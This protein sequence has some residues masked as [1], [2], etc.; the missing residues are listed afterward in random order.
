MEYESNNDIYEYHFNALYNLVKSLIGASPIKKEITDDEFPSSRLLLDIGSTEFNLFKFQETEYRAWSE[1]FLL[2][3]IKNI[4]SRRSIF[5]E[6]HYHGDGLEA[7]SILLFPKG[8]RVEVFFLF[9]ISYGST[10]NTDYDKLAQTLKSKVNNVDEIHVFILR[11]SISY[12]D[13]A[14][15]VNS[16]NVLNM[17]GFVK[18]FPIKEFFLQYFDDDEFD[19]FL[20]YANEF[21]EKISNEITY[22][23]VIIPSKQ[24]LLDFRLKKCNMLENLNYREIYNLGKSGRLTNDDFSKVKKNY[25]EN[26]MY[27]AM[28][29]YND[30]SE[31]FISAEWLFDIYHN[32]MGSLDLTGIISGYLK[33]IEQLIYKIVQFNIDKGFKIKIHGSRSRVEYT[34]DNEELIDKTLGSLNEFITSSKT[35]LALNK[36][37]RG[38]MKYA[39]SKWTQYQRNGYFHKHNLYKQDNK[40][41]EIRSLTLF[42]YFLILGGI[43][44]TE[45]QRVL[46]GIYGNNL[47]ERQILSQE[48]LYIKFK[49]WF[50][51]ALVFDLPNIVPGMIFTP[52]EKNG[53]WYLHV[54]LLKEFNRKKYISRNFDF[55]KPENMMMSHIYDIQPLFLY[56]STGEFKNIDETIK[57]LLNRYMSDEIENMKRIGGIIL[58]SDEEN[59]LIY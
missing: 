32:A 53:E 55:L 47:V 42:L 33:S 6:A 35:N 8:M 9:D 24:T 4:L 29:G 17:E 2:K 20:K 40:I 34:K 23:T 37:V 58:V 54:N 41:E 39:I 26:K 30:F 28:V 31:S 14:S 36:C 43:E 59:L 21:R 16:S 49:K 12:F 13:L 38:C 1:I 18:V 22:K 3:M 50:N 44:F 10:N 19:L 15:L 11:D 27:Q 48:N 5:F 56:E 52:I 7:N 57:E 46:L 25:F 51:L 45:E